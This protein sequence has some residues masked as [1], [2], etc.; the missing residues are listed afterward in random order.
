MA[1]EAIGG[2]VARLS[3]VEQLLSEKFEGGPQDIET[4]QAWLKA[5]EQ[6]RI[7]HLAAA[8]RSGVDE[9]K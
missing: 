1:R 6:L 5:L 2:N 8:G 7:T 3:Q 9:P 4:A